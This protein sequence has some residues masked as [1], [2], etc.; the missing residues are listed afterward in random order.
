MADQRGRSRLR[1]QRTSIRQ[2]T[3]G[4]LRSRAWS[5]LGPADCPRSRLGLRPPRPIMRRLLHW[6][7]GQRTPRPGCGGR[8]P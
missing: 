8:S 4:W 2:T 1:Q 6:P 7:P 5:R 3:A